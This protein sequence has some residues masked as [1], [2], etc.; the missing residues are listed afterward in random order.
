MPGLVFVGERPRNECPETGTAEMASVESWGRTAAVDRLPEGVAVM[1]CVAGLWLWG[2]AGNKIWEKPGVS[3]SC[4][5]GGV[6]RRSDRR[7]RS[8][9]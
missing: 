6:M 4:E 5:A 9:R 1:G 7:E 8:Q 2:N 3:R